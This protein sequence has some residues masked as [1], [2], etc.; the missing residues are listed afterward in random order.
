MALTPA[1]AADR[2]LPSCWICSAPLK[3]AIAH[4]KRSG[5][6]SI[7][8]FCGED[9]RHWRSFCNHEPTV[10]ELVQ[11]LEANLTPGDDTP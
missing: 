2:P 9:A 5:R 10:R 7:M 6:P 8:L 3:V 11:R 1:T 4:R